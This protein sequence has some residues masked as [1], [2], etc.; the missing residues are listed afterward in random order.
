MLVYIEKNFLMILP[1]GTNSL[2]IVTFILNNIY[3]NVF[4]TV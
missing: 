4:K 1:A 3:Q 2:A